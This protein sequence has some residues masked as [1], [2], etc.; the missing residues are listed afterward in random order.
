MILS[1]REY[2]ATI[3]GKAVESPFTGTRSLEVVRM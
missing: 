2:L 3:I 1:R